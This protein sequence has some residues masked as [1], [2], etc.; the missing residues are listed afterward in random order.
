[1]ARR[2]AR[3]VVSK[4]LPEEFW[5]LSFASLAPSRWDWTRRIGRTTYPFEV[6]PHSLSGHPYGSV[7]VHRITEDGSHTVRYFPLG[8]EE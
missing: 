8:A 5:L 3:H 4:A 1:M 2:R 7:A 6:A